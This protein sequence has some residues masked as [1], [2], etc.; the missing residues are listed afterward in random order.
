MAN[1]HRRGGGW[2]FISIKRFYICNFRHRPLT[3]KSCIPLPKELV[4]KKALTY[5]ENKDDQ[6]FKWAVTEAL[7]SVERDDKRRIKDL[8]REFE[9]LKWDGIKFSVSWKDID[10]FKRNN[11][12]AVNVHGYDQDVHACRFST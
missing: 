5:M 11:A 1:F 10:I 4:A 8:K 6:C 3:G 9:G 2:G 12:T 7:N